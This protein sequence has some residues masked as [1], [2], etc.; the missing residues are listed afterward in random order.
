MVEGEKTRLQIVNRG[1][2]TRGLVCHA[3]NCILSPAFI[4]QKSERQ[5]RSQ[6]LKHPLYVTN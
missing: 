4:N 3:K 2:T 6:V 5:L 1:Q